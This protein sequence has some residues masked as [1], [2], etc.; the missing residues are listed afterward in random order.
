[1][2]RAKQEFLSS[3]KGPEHVSCIGLFGTFFRIGL[4]TFGGGFA[5]SAVLRHEFVLKR[6]WITEKDFLN[7]LST[8][9]AV[10]GAVAVNIAFIE[11]SRLRG[12]RGGISAALGQICPSVLVIL[13]IVRFAA[14]YFDQP[15]VA[16]FLKGAAIAVAGQIAF[17]GFT[18]ARKLRRHWLNV[19]VCVLGLLVLGIGLHPVWAVAVAAGVGYLMMRERMM[20]NDA[21]DDGDEAENY[22]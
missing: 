18:F 2:S 12:L 22:K 15:A 9:T 7:T 6:G 21:T 13:L 3:H 5:M 14:P 4:M 11:G 1:M 16:A 8:A 10:P 17:A 20:P 19:A